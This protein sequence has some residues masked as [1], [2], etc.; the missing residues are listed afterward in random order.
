MEP[1]ITEV[2]EHVIEM[3][4]TKYHLIDVSN[5]LKENHQSWCWQCDGHNPAPRD[6]EDRL[7]IFDHYCYG[8]NKTLKCDPD[9]GLV[10]KSFEC[11]DWWFDLNEHRYICHAVTCKIGLQPSNCQAEIAS[12]FECVDRIK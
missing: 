2:Q 4:G 12:L 9:R 7:S 3:E 5:V 10:Y 6:D 8:R 1:K 11:K